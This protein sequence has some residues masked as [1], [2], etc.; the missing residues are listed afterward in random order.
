MMVI[1]AGVSGSGKTT[2]G[3][4]VAKRAGWPFADGDSFHPAA[5]VAKM[6]AGT[7]LTDDDRWPWLRAIGAWMDEQAAACRS[8]VV[9]CSA[10]KRAYREELLDGRPQARL[11]FLDAGHDL[12]A[13][14]LSARHGHFF[15]AALLNSQFDELEVPRPA[16]GALVL[17]ADATVDELVGAIITGLG[18][19]PG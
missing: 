12:D 15:P 17:S 8:C 4:L 13:R 16:E 3:S 6:T 2:V 9:A 19:V 7:P 14:R 11:V 5:N 18:I 10:L 1:V